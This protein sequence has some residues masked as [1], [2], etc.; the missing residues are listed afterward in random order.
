[1]DMGTKCGAI[2]NTHFPKKNKKNSNSPIVAKSMTLSF[3][4]IYDPLKNY[5]WW[6]N[7]HKFN[8]ILFVAKVAIIHT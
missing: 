5:S 2:G 6:H 3:I 8:G 7:L 4:M 1:M